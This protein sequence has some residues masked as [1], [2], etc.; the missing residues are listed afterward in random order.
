L[1]RQFRYQALHLSGAGFELYRAFYDDTWENRGALERNGKLKVPILA[2]LDEIS[3]IG[4]G[5]EQMM[6]GFAENV[7]WLLISKSAHWIVAC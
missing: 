3:Y 7:T 5:V 1:R 4:P 6:H 2:V